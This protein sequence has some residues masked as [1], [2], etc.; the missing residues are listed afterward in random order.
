MGGAGPESDVGHFSPVALCVYF[1]K[2]SLTEPEA[3]WPRWL[4]WLD[5]ELQESASM[6]ALYRRARVTGVHHYLSV[7][8]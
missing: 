6:Y 7:F 1:M 3:H 4:G 2:Q 8:T 5:N